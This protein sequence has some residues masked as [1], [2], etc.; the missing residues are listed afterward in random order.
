MLGI[1]AAA[2]LAGCH[3]HPAR[4][5]D[6]GEWHPNGANA[7]NLAAMVA[8]P[9]DL[10]RGHGDP[11][12]DGAEAADAVRRLRTGQV[13]PVAASIMAGGGGA[14]AGGSPGA[15]M[16]AGAAGSTTGN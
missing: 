10:V 15:G 2:L 16:G 8:N 7:A 9:L 12:S 13:A 4:Y 3:P 14:S 5:N 11:G 6:S 1:A